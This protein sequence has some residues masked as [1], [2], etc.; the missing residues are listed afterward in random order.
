[1]IRSL[2]CA[3]LRAA[4]LGMT[5]VFWSNALALPT[6]GRGTSNRIGKKGFDD[7]LDLEGADGNLFG[8]RTVP[9]FRRTKSSRELGRS[10]LPDLE[11]SRC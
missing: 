7:L 11:E 4:S 2:D 6:R 9:V 3:A 8:P 5:G 1:M 10:D